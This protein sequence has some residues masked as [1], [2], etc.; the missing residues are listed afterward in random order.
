MY[1]CA[2]SERE[3]ESKEERFRICLRNSNG[4]MRQAQAGKI[5]T[6]LPAPFIS[7]IGP[8]F[9]DTAVAS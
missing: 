3:D 7:P 8:Y 9:T 1:A 2:E 5:V 4:P 6:P